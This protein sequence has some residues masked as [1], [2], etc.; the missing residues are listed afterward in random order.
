MFIQPYRV[1]RAL[2]Y[3]PYNI[4]ICNTCGFLGSPKAGVQDEPLART[5]SMGQPVRALVLGREV[6]KIRLCRGYIGVT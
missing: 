2:M 5:R 3:N 4:R 1:I 6:P